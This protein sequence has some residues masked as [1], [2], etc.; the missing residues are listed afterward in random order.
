[1]CGSYKKTSRSILQTLNYLL[2]NTGPL[3]VHFWATHFQSTSGPLPGHFRTTSRPL[4]DQFWTTSGPLPDHSRTTSGLLSDYFPLPDHFRS[5]SG[6]NLAHFWSALQVLFCSSFDALMVPLWPTGAFAVHHFR[7]TCSS[8]PVH[9]MFS[10]T[11]IKY[12]ELFI[13]TYN[14][15]KHCTIESIIM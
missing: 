4:L 15:K 12:I 3:P 1:M 8:L 7:F 14:S 9:F 2:Y 10:S 11:H 13:Q 6:P 5:T